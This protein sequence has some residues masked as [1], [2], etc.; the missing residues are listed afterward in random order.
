MDSMG[1]PIETYLD[2]LQ[3][4]N[5]SETTITGY[6]YQLLRFRRWRWYDDVSV[7]T[8]G[9]LVEYL[10]THSKN[11]NTWGALRGFFAFHLGQ[12]SPARELKAPREKRKRQRCLSEE[13]VLTL[14]SSLDTSTHIGVRD[15]AIVLLGLDTG[16]RSAEL[17]R[18]TLDDVHLDER[19]LSVVVKGGQL[20]WGVFSDYTATALV[21]WL[22]VRKSGAGRA[23]FVNVLTGSKLT[24]SGLRVIFRRISKRCGFVVSPHDLRRTFATLSISYGAPTRVVQVAGRWSDVRMVER[25]TQALNAKQIAGW[26]PTKRLFDNE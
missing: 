11:K 17:C 20:G 3:N 7:W 4:L 19:N 21:R 8:K 12:L 26:L 13:Q 6:R 16:L 1:D 24:N 23:F 14:L 2:Y 15:T 22:G 18:L 9:E 25:Y 5:R 10:N